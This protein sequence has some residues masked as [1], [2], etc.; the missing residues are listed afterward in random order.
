M[1]AQNRNTLIPQLTQ[2]FALGAY[3]QSPGQI[4][5]FDDTQN[6]PH[7]HL[8]AGALICFVGQNGEEITMS[9][10]KYLEIWPLTESGGWWGPWVDQL[11][12]YRSDAQKTLAF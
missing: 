8:H 12:W 4:N 6:A 7:P 9:M 2:S 1:T 11:F 10:K 5:A 3:D